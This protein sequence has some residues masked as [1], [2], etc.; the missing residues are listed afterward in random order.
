MSA[1]GNGK[2]FTFVVQVRGVGDPRRRGG[3]SRGRRPAA[4]AQRRRRAVGVALGL[5]VVGADLQRRGAVVERDRGHRVV[6]GIGRCAEDRRRI[7]LVVRPV[8][9]PHAVPRLDRNR[10]DV[11]VDVDDLAGRGIVERLEVRPP[12]VG[13]DRR[14]LALRAAP[15]L[16]KRALAAR[17]RG[18]VVVRP[19]RLRDRHA[20][21]QRDSDKHSGS[22]NPPPHHG[23]QIPLLRRDQ[24]EAVAKGICAAR[25]AAPVARLLALDDS[26]E[27]GDLRCGPPDVLNGKIEVNR[28][29]VSGE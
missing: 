11:V 13:D 12:V 2:S 6:L 16:D 7:A 17:V 20:Q 10:R 23:P 3:R 5:A 15:Q 18:A 26:A 29:P 27:P 9:E 8:P 22:R 14:A 4:A 1:P 21:A 19:P 24:A 28:R 25:Q